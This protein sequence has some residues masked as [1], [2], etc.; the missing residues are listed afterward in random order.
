MRAWWQEIA[1]YQIYP[2][3]FQDS[4]QDGI[5]DLA[6]ILSRLDYIKAIGVDAIWIGPIYQSP[7]IDNGYDVS[8]FRAIDPVFGTMEDL[9]E[10]IHQ[11]HQR[12]MYLILDLV[13]NHTSDLHPWFQKA[14]R[15]PQSEESEYYIFRDPRYDASGNP[16]EPT[17]W[18]GFVGKAW[19]YQPQRKQYY[20]KLFA[21]E[22]PDLNWENPKLREQMHD[23]ATYYLKLGVDGFRIDA[24]AHLG[25]DTTFTDIPVQEKEVPF[26]MMKFSNR[27][28]VFYYLEEFKQKV[29]SNYDCLCIGEVGGN[30][31]IAQAIRY[32]GYEEGSL[33]MVFTFDHCWSNGLFGAGPD[34][35]RNVDV[36]QLKQIFQ[37]WYTGLHEKAWQALYWHNHDHPRVVSQYGDDTTYHAESA[38]MLCNVLYFMAGTPFLYNGEEIGMTNVDYDDLK[39]FTDHSA[40]AFIQ[41]HQGELTTEQMLA[42]LRLTSRDNARS[43]MQ[44]NDQA[45]AGFSSHTPCTKVNKNYNTINVQAQE[46]DPASILNHYRKVLAFRKQTPYQD[47]ILSGSFSLVAPEHEDIFAYERMGISQTIVVIANFRDRNCSLTRKYSTLDVLVQNYSDIQYDGQTFDLRPFESVVFVTPNSKERGL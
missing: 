27:E 21:K 25:R 40:Q 42:I 41:A 47:I 46:H 28:E 3:S 13:L 14:I 36:K 38:K 22:M 44:W 37:T 20:M 33:Q 19:V 16:Q 18:Y 35:K 1:V 31:D 5:G 15:D 11:I 12:K 26:D 24:V 30:A 9:Q 34:A 10:L 7:M 8:D 17:N 23:I 29:F 45:N 43:P 2:R 6:G 32:A 39:D 4:N